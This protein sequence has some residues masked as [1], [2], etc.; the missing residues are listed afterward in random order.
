MTSSLFSYRSGFQVQL[1]AS[2]GNPDSLG[3]ITYIMDDER[4]LLRMH[5]RT[6]A[7]LV[8]VYLPFKQRTEECVVGA[9][10]SRHCPER[11]EIINNVT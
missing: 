7:P 2:S 4:R 5:F 9:Q 1:I 3:S 6:N 10:N 8:D 11:D